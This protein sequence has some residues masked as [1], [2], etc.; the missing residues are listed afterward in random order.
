MKELIILLTCVTCCG[1][2]ELFAQGCSDAGFCTVDALKNPDADSSE[3]TPNLLK[4]G[5]VV[6]KADHD[7]S[8][9]SSFVE[10]KRNFSKHWSTSVKLTHLSQVLDTISQHRLADAFVTGGYNLD[11]GFTFTAG[12]KI[13]FTNGNLQRSNRALPLDFQPSLGT[14]DF[15]AGA[16]WEHQRFRVTAAIQQPLTQNK[17]T[18]LSTDYDSSSVLSGFQS[19]KGFER[20]G[21][22]LLRVVYGQPL[23]KRWTISPGLLG[24][25]HLGE[26][27]YETSSGIRTSIN[28][29]SGL[30][31]N[32]TLFIQYS[33][34]E[35]QKLELSA[36]TPFV[37]RES[38][39]D[40]LTRSIVLGLEY[41]LLF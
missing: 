28:G 15:I 37:V 3:K 19:T 1:N 36:G 40:G 27:T 35:R 21:D 25:Y 5:L 9:F 11:N 8:I 6:G 13:P 22:V 33:L 2:F 31:L 26:D 10:Y 32:G 4:I 7:I 24:I 18:F 39:P 29:S 30:T 41:K 23:G 16:S 14:F 17:N 20:K 38:R 12:V 34:T